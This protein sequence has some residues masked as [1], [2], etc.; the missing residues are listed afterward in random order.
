MPAFRCCILSGGVG[1]CDFEHMSDVHPVEQMLSLPEHALAAA[2]V[3]F[4]D[5]R[6]TDKVCIFAFGYSSTAPDIVSAYADQASTVPVPVISDSRLPA[7]V[8]DMT[9]V[10]IVSY[11]GDEPELLQVYEDAADRG[12]TVYCLTSGGRL[13]EV[14]DDVVPLPL[15]MTA[16]SATGYELGIL[17]SMIQSMGICD[18]RD[19]LRSVCPEMIAYRDSL[20][21]MELVEELADDISG[22]VPA[23]YGTSDFR[24]AFKRW[25]MAVNEDGCS[26]A[27]YGDLPE[28][29]HNELVGWFDRNPHAPE[30][31]VIVLRGR[32]KS[33]LLNFIV[34]NMVEILREEGRQVM[35]VDFDGDSA[36]LKSACGVMLGDTVANALRRRAA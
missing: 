23:I 16:R 10:I 36:M 15:G 2:D 29:D 31:R 22:N 13:G 21:D 9:A 20:D 24:A 6:R 34:K 35:T 1:C 33:D 19:H 3:D 8:D 32:T 30:L 25:K 4:S 14:A 18:A 12:C 17:C 7:W 27:F 11:G 5:V 26:L 28:F